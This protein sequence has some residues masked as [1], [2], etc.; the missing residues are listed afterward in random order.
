LKS[1]FCD[2]TTLSIEDPISG[3]RYYDIVETGKEP[4]L[5]EIYVSTNFLVDGS[6]PG[7]GCVEQLTMSLETQVAG[8]YWLEIQDENTPDIN[9]E[10]DASGFCDY[11]VLEDEPLYFYKYDTYAFIYL[12]INTTEYAEGEILYDQTD[13][14]IT[15]PFRVTFYTE[16]G[17]L[18][19]SLTQSFTIIVTDNMDEDPCAQAELVL[20]SYSA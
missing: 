7:E 4:E 20:S 10:C 3:D 8:G 14:T 1:D 15:A 5:F 18:V 6:G 11:K 17:V 16:E 13:G 12:H 2:F 9:V 19:E